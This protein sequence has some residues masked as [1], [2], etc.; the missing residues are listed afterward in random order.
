MELK[1]QGPKPQEETLTFPVTAYINLIDRGLVI[2]IELSPEIST[3]NMGEVW[4]KK[5]SSN[6]VP[7][8]VLLSV[9]GPENIYL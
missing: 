4:W 6:Q 1:S 2:G 8:W 5:L 3:K 7:L 9:L